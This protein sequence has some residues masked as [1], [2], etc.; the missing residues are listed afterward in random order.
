MQEC[1]LAALQA[2][3]FYSPEWLGLCGGRAAKR[4]ADSWAPSKTSDEESLVL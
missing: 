4:L 2:L 3:T 1:G